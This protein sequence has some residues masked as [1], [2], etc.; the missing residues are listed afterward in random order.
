MMGEHRFLPW[1][2]GKP[3]AAVEH[4]APQVQRHIT[5]VPVGPQAVA[6]AREAVTEHFPAAGVVPDSAFADAVL[7][8]VGELVANVLR[9]AAHTPAMEVGLTVGAGHLVIGVAD[10]DPRL[11][12][13]T[14][15]AMGSGLR[16]VTELAAEYD[17]DVSAE[18]AVDQHGEVI[19]VRFRIPS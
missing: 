10:A 7:L 12:D 2:K 11:P 15:E 9:H 19:L 3:A 17:G 13:L 1:R 8:V 4:V 16:T 18:P 6:R 5:S 14:P